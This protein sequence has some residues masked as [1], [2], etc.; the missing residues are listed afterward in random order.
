MV[1]LLL[2]LLAVGCRYLDVAHSNVDA[3]TL[4]PPPPFPITGFDSRQK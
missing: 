4:H 3:I 2:L 1:R